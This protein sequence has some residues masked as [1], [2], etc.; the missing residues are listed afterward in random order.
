[1]G[2]LDQAAILLLTLGE[3]NAS[4]IL[5]HM[6][7]RQVQRLGTSMT[8]L[9][10]VSQE[11]L[12]F[13][14][15]D[16]LKQAKTQTS[17]GVDSKEYV[18]KT[19][20]S[21]LGEDRASNIIDRILLT[22]NTQGLDL[23]KWMDPRAISDLIEFEHPQI[24]SIVLSYIDS[25]QA[26]EVLGRFDDDKAV[27][28]LMRMSKLDSV[29]PEALVELNDFLEKISVGSKGGS[30]TALGGVEN[31]SEVM[32][33]IESNREAS[34][35]E[36]IKK[37][38]EKIATQI[39]DLMFVFDNLLDV[40]D[41]G[42]QSILR[43]ISSQVLQVALRSC[44]TELK[45]KFFKNMSSR[46]AELLKDDIEAMGPVKLSDVE[47][48]QREVVAAA[49]KLADSGELVISKKGEEMI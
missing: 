17:L 34:I 27:D 24:I 32:N 16:F 49:N 35:L 10:S 40:D 39:Q 14:M 47:G 29:N 38:D 8:S 41:R 26:A 42:I 4:E 23:L 13:A 2:G 19:L 6:G 7:H 36:K 48:A 5:K 12:Q 22:A 43:E 28:I 31:V 33:C 30:S 11:Q 25:D 46:A 45:D 15:I 37:I 44:S 20:E 9:K 3:G 18:R 1:M 21:A